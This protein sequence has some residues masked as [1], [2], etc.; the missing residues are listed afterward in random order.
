[1]II[2]TY[3][4]RKQEGFMKADVVFEGGGMRGIGF[5]GALR[6]LEGYGF[7]WEKTAGTS[8]GAVIA[9]LIAVGYNAKE[10]RDIMTNTNFNKFLDRDRVQRVPVVG[11]VL[12]FLKENAIYSGDYLEEWIGQLLKAKGIEKFKD[13]YKDGDFTL[14]MIA[15]D[16]SRKTKL[17]LPYELV[18]YGINPM[19]FSIA[20]AVR[21]SIS[22]PFY[23]KPVRLNY[24]GGVSYIVDGAVC[25][26]F[27]INIF[28]VEGIPRWPTFGFKFVDPKV[29]FTAE[30][31]T[32]PFSLL[33]DI[34]DTMG[35]R[36]NVEHLK[37]ENKARTIFIPTM[38]VES[39]EFDIGKEKSI[40]LYKSGFRSAEEFMKDWD[41]EDYIK[42]YR[43][44]RRWNHILD[45]KTYS[46]KW[47]FGKI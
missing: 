37:E 6:C 40:K 5:V 21:M 29:S 42:K 19:D 9:A 44:P 25:C 4:I 14:K 46:K 38:G 24:N 7:T 8:V 39:T 10:L 30:G 16:V 27:P 43:A 33:F 45:I 2:I 31:K 13:L 32:D 17:I 12:G 18:K 3:S 28:D 34:A 15:S 26:N 35:G 23:F 22:I 47:I 11:K 41:F 20:R 36:I 1:M